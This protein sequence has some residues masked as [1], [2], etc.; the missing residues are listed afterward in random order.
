M[1]SCPDTDIDLV[2]ISLGDNDSGKQL[3]NSQ[4]KRNGNCFYKI[5]QLT[6][7]TLR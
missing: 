6:V 4:I 7:K 5:N 2:L 3:I 1:G